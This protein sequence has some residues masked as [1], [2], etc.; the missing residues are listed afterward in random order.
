MRSC[1]T[2]AL[3]ALSMVIAW[4]S[5]TPDTAAI[6]LLIPWDKAKHFLGFFGLAVLAVIAFPRAS[7]LWIGLALM[8]YGGAIEIAQAFVGRDRDI[9]DWAAY[10]AGVLACF[11]GM[12]ASWARSPL[13]PQA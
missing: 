11:S 9:L 10:G 5:L 7:L 2:V 1:A 3:A 6:S 8:V 13:G 12:A 4:T